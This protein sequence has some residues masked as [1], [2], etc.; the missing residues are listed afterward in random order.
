M[1]PTWQLLLAAAATLACAAKREIAMSPNSEA[2]EESTSASEARDAHPRAEAPT[3]SVADGARLCTGDFISCMIVDDGSVYCWGPA[4]SPGAQLVEGVA[5]AKRVACGYARACA[6]SG[7]GT[8]RCWEHDRFAAGGS[9]ARDVVS[10]ALGE[11]LLCISDR[12]G[13][14]ACSYDG[15][16]NLKPQ[17]GLS[18]IVKVVA[19]YYHACALSKDGQVSCWGRDADYQLGVSEGVSFE[20][21]DILGEQW[22]SLLVDAPSQT[23]D[24][25]DLAGNTEL[26]RKQALECLASARVGDAVSSRFAIGATV[27]KDGSVVRIEPPSPSHAAVDERALHDCFAPAL[28]THFLLPHAE[29]EPLEVTVLIDAKSRDEADRV[30]YPVAAGAVDLNARG[31]LTCAISKRG[32]TSCWGSGPPY[33]HDQPESIWAPTGPA[34][35]L[36]LDD[37]VA[38]AI[39]WR[40]ICVLRKDSSVRCFGAN[41]KEAFG[42][43]PDAQHG[44]VSEIRAFAGYRA[45]DL[46][47]T[48]GCGIDP[49]G[50]VKC[51]GDNH[52]HLGV[53]PREPRR[54]PPTQ[55]PGL[56]RLE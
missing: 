49:D 2:A 37:A 21:G 34:R 17:E 54:L 14:V 18:D 28:S 11:W 5:D 45:L 42:V 7:D 25:R 52:G 36:G 9:T 23:A 53:A 13:D 43:D 38:V 40:N 35:I 50:I 19:G 1:K 47:P 44:V 55:I 12:R 48:F 26:L 30:V 46:G 6:I 39:G 24:F 4:Q 32:S 27:R 51:F 20:H 3:E 41:P 8:A 22:L 10:I 31:Y 15:L 33:S 56:P 29:P 16:S